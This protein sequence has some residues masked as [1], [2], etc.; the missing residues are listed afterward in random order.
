M[1]ING[2]LNLGSSCKNFKAQDKLIEGLKNEDSFAIQC[3]LKQVEGICLKMIKGIGL[4]DESLADIIHDGLLAL[5]LKIQNQSYDP[6]LSTPQTYLVSI[7]KNLA[8]NA[9]RSKKQIKTLELEENHNG[10][11]EIEFSIS[12]YEERF[13]ILRSMLNEIGSPCKELIQIKYID[14]LSDEEQ[15][16]SKLTKYSSLES[17][18]VSRSQCMKKLTS[19][20]IKYKAIYESI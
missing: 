3:I 13:K 8:L 7:C 18:R 14:G 19:I 9:S 17:L 20:S 15:I 6:K 2:I 1:S 4:S 10:V 11:P 5:I 12:G 16:K